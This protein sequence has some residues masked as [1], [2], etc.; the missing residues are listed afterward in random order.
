MSKANS[1][2]FLNSWHWLVEALGHLGEAAQQV[3]DCLEALARSSCVLRA[4]HVDFLVD[5]TNLWLLL[6]KDTVFFNILGFGGQ[7][8][9]QVVC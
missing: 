4:H 7:R 5:A 6:T 8:S 2:I 9:S 1:L 3:L